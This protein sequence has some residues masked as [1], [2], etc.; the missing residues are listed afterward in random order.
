MTLE[1][2]EQL[3]KAVGSVLDIR[4]VFPEVSAIVQSLLPHDRLTMTLHDGRRTLIAHAFSN[5]D[6]PFL[7]RA[8]G[9]EFEAMDDGSSKI[10]RRPHSRRPRPSP[11][12]R[13]TTAN[14]PRP[15][16][17][18]RCCRCRARARPALR[19]ALLVEAGRGVQRGATSGSRGTSRFTSPLVSRTSNWPRPPA[20]GRRPCAQRA[21]RGTR[22]GA[23]RRA[24]DR[25][26]V[27]AGW[28]VSRAAWKD[29]GSRGDAGRRDRY[30]GAP[31]W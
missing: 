1:V 4:Q 25:V 22:A 6:G 9:S 13:P 31:H 28:P 7:V 18:A 24:A 21:A 30:D 27:T 8:T 23:V 14:A 26:P 3:L 11:S 15:R 5:D 12:I 20:N 16:A 29:S 19:A 2:S 17:I 10:I